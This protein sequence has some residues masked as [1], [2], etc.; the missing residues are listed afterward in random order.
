MKKFVLS[1]F[2]F[3]AVAFF[4]Y[5]GYIILWGSFA[6]NAL[7]PNLNYRIGSKGHM[8]TRLQ[9]VKRI[10]SVDILFLGS[11]HAYRGFDPRIFASHQ[12]N[13]FN[14]GSSS[15]TPIQ[16]A[17]LLERYLDHIKPKSIIY[18]VYPTTFMID[19]IESSLDIIAN[20]RNDLLSL[21]MAFELNHLKTY[22]TLIYGI[23]RNLFNLNTS[24]TEA[25]H[26][27][28]DTYI[29]G[30]YVETLPKKFAPI[31]FSK[32]KI[33]LN[34]NHLNTFEAIIS[35]IKKGTS[36]SP[37]FSPRYHPAITP[38]IPT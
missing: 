37:W 20:D 23:F 6:P 33:T 14:L 12:F 16:T 27:K 19:G 13:T 9:E 24:F 28:N 32:Q 17:I 8:F 4:T 22:N 18:E 34:Q 36:N 35:E 3:I 5:I 7:K 26:K 1:L 25:I 31:T 38:A 15:Q 11:S 2:L 29:L 21:K 30:G 10:D